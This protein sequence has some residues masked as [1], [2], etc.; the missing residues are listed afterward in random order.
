M[1]T[2]LRLRKLFDG[3]G[4][5][6]PEPT[7]SHTSVDSTSSCNWATRNC[8][9]FHVFQTNAVMNLGFTSRAYSAVSRTVP[10][11]IFD[12]RCYRIRQTRSRLVFASYMDTWPSLIFWHLPTGPFFWW[13]SIFCIAAHLN[14]FLRLLF[15]RV[16]ID[17]CNRLKVSP[18]NLLLLRDRIHLP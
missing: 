17:F 16:K 14:T 5:L 15:T 10:R 11:I 6:T 8:P 9:R 18:G 13:I 3:L 2:T 12:F 1:L 7:Q 4:L